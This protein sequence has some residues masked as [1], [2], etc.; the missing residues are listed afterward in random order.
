MLAEEG[1]LLSQER[2]PPL[3]RIFFFYRISSVEIED[4][5]RIDAKRACPSHQIRRLNLVDR[6]IAFQSA[7]AR[8]S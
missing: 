6:H 3:Q 1:Y 7:N 4:V 2:I 8:D 5:R